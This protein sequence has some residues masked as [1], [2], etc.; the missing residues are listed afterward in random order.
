[1]NNKVH[2]QSGFTLIELL[3]SLTLMGMIM[4]LLSA[5]LRLI[6]SSWD[7]NTIRMEKLESFNRMSGLFRRDVEHLRRIVQTVGKER[8]FVFLGKPKQL[9]FVVME[10]P[11]PTLPGLYLVE[12][13]NTDNKLYRSRRNY[14]KITGKIFPEVSGSKVTLLDQ[15]FSYRF[16]YGMLDKNKIRWVNQWEPGDQ[17]PSLIKLVATDQN[18]KDP[19]QTVP[20]IVRLKINGEQ[21]CITGSFLPCTAATNGILKTTKKLPLARTN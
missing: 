4:V 1:M 19:L 16:Q 14:D 17:L 18:K 12:Y 15:N 7:R 9:A 13:N 10:P 3:I 8:N 11:F 5:G 2:S 21:E 6:S 20:V